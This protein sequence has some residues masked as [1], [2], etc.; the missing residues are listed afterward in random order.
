MPDPVL[1]SAG[2]DYV[3]GVNSYTL[4]TKIND[5]MA[6]MAMNCLMRGG[7][8]QTRPGSDTIL[9]LPRGNKLQGV[10]F[11]KPQGGVEHL[12]FAVD[13]IV[14]V[15]PYPFVSYTQLAG[16]QFAIDS[17]MLSWAVCL[18]STD[19]D[20]EGRLYYLDQPY[21]IL[22]MQ[23]GRTRAAFWDGSTARHL[24][25]TPI[26]GELTVAGKDETPLGLWM[27]W[28]NNRL[29]VSRG[30]QI[31]ASDI[32]NPL[33]FTDQE[34]LNEGRAFYLPD[35]CTGLVETSDQAGLIAFTETTG[36]FIQ[37]S[38]Q[39]RTQWLS[40][41]EFQKTILQRIGC[42]A[43]RSI[44]SQYGIIWWYSHKG[45]I[46]L[47]DALRLN[48]TSRLDV[49]DNE[50]FGSK[51]NVSYNLT[52]ICGTF[53]ENI[54]LQSLPNGDKYNTHTYVLDQAPFDGN[55]NAWAGYWTGWRPVEWTNG[56]VNGEE[57]IFMAS[58]DY[59]NNFRIWE[60][61]LASKL[62]NGLPI[63]SWVQFKEHDF[64]NLEYKEFSYAEIRLREIQGEVNVMAA[65]AGSKGAF[66]KVLTK[67]IEATV[68]QVYSD[69]SYGEGAETLAGYRP[70]QREIRTNQGS[71]P[72]DCNSAC[73]EIELR[74]LIDKS[75]SLMVAWS[76]IAGI[77]AYR[78]FAKPVNDDMSGLCEL[79]EDAPRLLNDEGCGAFNYFSNSEAIVKYTA[80]STYTQNDNNGIPVSYTSNRASY[81]SQTDADRL[82]KDS[83][84]TYVLSQLGL[85]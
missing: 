82:A 59:D 18:K 58:R 53:Y 41:P 65:I 62:D 20:N 10:K 2:S 67:K 47:N 15:S 17:D 25:P 50:M 45:L 79:N 11:F 19:Y 60:A 57:R 7:I 22:M 80:T 46:N 12:V 31:F 30:N 34:Y 1:N 40:T 4:P 76:G 27:L 69:S 49:Q 84:K 38:I 24:D 35:T 8:P 14:Y 39:D 54:L 48:I 3:L 61:M 68:G 16:I 77:S 73:V 29:W 63:T 71:D 43:P 83:A 52:G 32:G 6:V 13:G 5:N 70:Q 75:F 81:I 23:D 64:G 51:Y 44:V 78:I 72:S 36:T 26:S 28:S 21:S 42:V 33:K 56:V 37:S 74:G 85:L 9:A 55:A 66:Q